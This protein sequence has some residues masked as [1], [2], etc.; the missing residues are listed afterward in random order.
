VARVA[1]TLKVLPGECPI[2]PSP[3]LRIGDISPQ[4]A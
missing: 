3:P 1:C 2:C 4:P